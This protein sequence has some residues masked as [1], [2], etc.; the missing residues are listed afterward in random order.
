MYTL[1][2][3]VISF[4]SHFYFAGDKW[5]L[6]NTSVAQYHHLVAQHWTCHSGLYLKNQYP[7]SC[8]CADPTGVTCCAVST[9]NM[10]IL[11]AKDYK[12]RCY[13]SEIVHEV[14]LGL[15]SPEV[16]PNISINQWAAPPGDKLAHNSYNC[17]CIAVYN[18]CEST[19]DIIIVMWCPSVPS[20]WF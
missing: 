17:M 7:A 2:R 19:E 12:R 1:V 20:E 14:A 8:A 11:F 15:F 10:S 5:R 9:C 6:T 4:L 3:L 16:P 18:V 13:I